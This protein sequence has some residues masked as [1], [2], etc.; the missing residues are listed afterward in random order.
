M[1]Q[2]KYHIEPNTV[3]ETLVIPLYGKKRCSEQ[4]PQFFRDESAIALVEKIDYDWSRYQDNVM[5]RFGMV[6]TGM[7]VKD[8]AW[9]IKDY[10]KSHPRALVVNLGCGLDDMFPRVDNGQIRCY[11]LDLPDVIAIRNELMPPREREIN[12]AVDLNDPQWVEQLDFKP[13]D[14]A[15]FFASGVFYYFEIPKMHALLVNMEQ[16]FPGARVCFD[17]GNLKALKLMLK[18]YIK[19]SGM[20][21]GGYFYLEHPQSLEKW[22]PR[23]K[24]SEKGY[25][26]G[27]EPLDKSMPWLFRFMGKFGDKSYN[28]RIIRIEFP[29]A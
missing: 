2:K 23:S 16:A 15:V 10:V 22:L 21:I 17:I 20:E 5:T 12:L 28:L 3:Q 27:Y 11:N 6:E 14:G 19:G 9:E 18:T 13:E 4:Y 29:K 26:T 24:I 1:E 7:R 8:L 25:M